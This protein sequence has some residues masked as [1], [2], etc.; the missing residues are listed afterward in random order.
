VEVRVDALPWIQDSGGGARL[1]SFLLDGRFDEG[2]AE[3]V[4]PRLQA[5][6][7]ALGRIRLLGLGE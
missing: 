3:D 6:L 7:D 1:Q 2:R 4:L 5:R